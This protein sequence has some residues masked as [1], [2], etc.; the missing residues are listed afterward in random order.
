MS[1]SGPGMWMPKQKTGKN[2][3]VNYTVTLNGAKHICAR[4]FRVKSDA[5]DFVR[6][7]KNTL[8]KN[9]DVSSFHFKTNKLNT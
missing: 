6:D 4:K 2:W 8:R 3:I 1:Y 5:T 7:S 9:S